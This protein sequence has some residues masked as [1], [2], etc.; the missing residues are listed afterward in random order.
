MTATKSVEPVINTSTNNYPAHQTQSSN[1]YQ[2]EVTSS[3]NAKTWLNKYLD[4]YV[5][6]YCT[7]GK[8]NYYRRDDKRKKNL[9]QLVNVTTSTEKQAV[10]L[11]IN[12]Y[13]TI[14]EFAEG[15]RICLVGKVHQFCYGDISLCSVTVL[16]KVD[17]KTGKLET[18]E[19]IVMPI[20]QCWKSWS[21]DIKIN[22]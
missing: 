20:D 15:D 9:I 12:K 21:C 5:T 13:R 3:G 14:S 22:V 17:K 2:Y 7:I 16:G 6:I 11:F 18:S 4:L 19:D 1:K 10:D 8:S